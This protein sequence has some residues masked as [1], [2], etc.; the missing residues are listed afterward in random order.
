MDDS[1]KTCIDID[2]CADREVMEKLNIQCQYGCENTPGSYKCLENIQFD[3]HL[4][5]DDEQDEEYEVEN[6][7]CPDG[8]EINKTAH[9]CAGITNPP[10]GSNKNK[11]ENNFL[12]VLLSVPNILCAFPIKRCHCC[13]VA[14]YKICEICCLCFSL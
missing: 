9:N 5:D 3:V 6:V 7:L 14:R 11:R 12:L 1:W 2:E 13:L 4:S 10:S 8:F